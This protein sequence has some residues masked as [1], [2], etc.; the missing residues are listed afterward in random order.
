MGLPQCATPEAPRTVPGRAA[1]LWQQLLRF[2]QRNR[3]PLT[4]GNDVRLLLSGG[5]IQD[6]L[7][8]LVHAA[9]TTLHLE[10]YAW[11]D[12]TTGRRLLA[13]LQ[14]AQARGVQVQGI[15]D[16]FGS[17][18]GAAMIRASGLDLRLFHPIGRLTRWRLWQKRNHRKLLIADGARAIVGSANWTDA[19]DERLSPGGYRDL[20][21]ELQGPAVAHLEEDFQTSWRRV[22][23][24]RE[25]P[26]PAPGAPVDGPGWHRDVPV[27]VVSSLNGGSRTL[28]RHLRLMFRQVQTAALI[29]NAYFI[30]A[31][32]LLRVLLRAVHRGVKVDL[33]APGKSDHALVRAASRATFGKLLR[34]GVR[35]WERRGQVFHAKV[36]LLDGDLVMVGTAN[37]DSASFRHNLELYLMVRSRALGEALLEA[38]QGDQEQSRLLSLGEWQK[39][40]TFR[41]LLHRLAYRFWWW[42]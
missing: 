24:G 21:L 9:R 16:H 1:N 35:I 39:R 29:A 25:G 3:L 11:A 30:P 28:R 22:G 40:T 6:A 37:L 8:E 42:L 2:G 12:D 10:I 41:R 18:D 31:P 38:L 15:V 7:L 13:A 5:R 27:Q 14:Q 33:I 20:G 23:G 17:W 34:A 32:A 26:P 4:E 36:A 19:Y